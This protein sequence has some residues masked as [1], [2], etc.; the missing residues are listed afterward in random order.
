[1]GYSNKQDTPQ[2]VTELKGVS[3]IVACE[4][5]HSLALTDD[6][7]IYVWGKNTYG[8]LSLGNRIEQRTPKLGPKLKGVRQIAAGYA[9]C[10]ALTK[11]GNVF[12][13]G[14][15]ECGQLGLG[16]LIDQNTPR[17]VVA[18]QNISRVAAGFTY[19]LALTADG[20]VY[21]W[22]SNDLC[23][24]NN[25]EHHAPQPVPEL[26]D[27]KQ[28]AAGDN[29]SLALTQHGSVFAWSPPFC[30]GNVGYPT[31]PQQAPV[32]KYVSQIAQRGLHALA[33]TANGVAYAWGENN[34]GQLGLRHWEDKTAPHK[35]N[36]IPDDVEK[37]VERLNSDRIWI[38][39]KEKSR[40]RLCDELKKKTEHKFFRSLVKNDSNKQKNKDPNC[41]QSCC[42][43]S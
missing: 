19:S 26:K 1:M 42:P 17:R 4:S 40:H 25:D 21:T 36:F 5:D 30:L 29:H 18:L 32:L 7:A 38:L 27:I 31:T 8:Q 22:G 11:D 3:Q 34:H 43:I 20:V 16:Y 23:V 9:H 13:W 37:Y 41:Q 10:L 2:P 28:I 33:L 6:S 35:V 14:W 12:G 15:N 24:P 39:A